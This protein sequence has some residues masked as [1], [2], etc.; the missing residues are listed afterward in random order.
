LVVPEMNS[1]DLFSWVKR[2]SGQVQGRMRLTGR[3]SAI[4]RTLGDGSA[5]PARP[6]VEPAGASLAKWLEET[7]KVKS[8]VV[9]ANT[10][11]RQ[12]MASIQA[13]IVFAQD[14]LSENDEAGRKALRRKIDCAEKCH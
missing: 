7:A 9:E 10:S 3:R 4:A 12:Q 6:G 11:V 1:V 14:N 13:A 8:Y 2:M 5:S